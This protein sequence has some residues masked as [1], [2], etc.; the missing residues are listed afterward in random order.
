M[1]TFIPK[2]DPTKI[3]NPGE[4][5][6]AETL[7][8]HL[9]DDIRVIHSLNW[10]RKGRSGVLVEGECD[11]V[12]LVPNKGL[13]FVEVKGGILGFDTDLGEWWRLSPHNNRRAL[14]KDPFKQVQSNMHSILDHIKE[15][16]GVPTLNFTYGFATIFPDG[17]FQGKLPPGITR[18]QILDA[19]DLENPEKRLHSILDLFQRRN[20]TAL[21]RNE[22]H[23]IESALFTKFDIV[24]VT[25]RNLEEQ[26]RRLHRLTEEQRTLLDILAEQSTAAI[27]GG[28]GTGKTLLAVAKAQQVAQSGM[29]TLLLCYNRPLRNWLND[30]VQIDFEQKLM[31][32]TYHELVHEFCIAAEL[33]FNPNMTGDQQEFWNNHAPDLLMQACDK[34]PENKKFDAV[35]VD[36]GQDFQELWW[37]S[38]DSVFKEPNNKECFYVYFDP[39][40]NLFLREAVSLPS[41]LGNPFVLQRNCRNSPEIADYC[42]R[43]IDDNLDDA[44]H[45]LE[46]YQVESRRL[47]F[48]KIAELVHKLTKPRTGELKPSQIAVLV[49]P[50]PKND[51]PTKFKSIST[52]G[53]LDSW[54]SGKGVL[55]ETYPRFKG[56][57]ADVVIILTAPL[58]GADDRLRRFNYVACSRAKHILHIVEVIGN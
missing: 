45:S 32:K 36:E 43:I 22:I 52:T 9:S 53:D 47:G 37:H 1:V 16:L 28:A 21:S 49:P 15:H 44:T 26:E 23:R 14:N 30:T 5:K 12:I 57:E 10:V 33:D 25:W 39:N 40:Q 46:V 41:E 24:P 11:F 13:L 54:R 4:R 27:K 56:L 8:K 35:V 18:K 19:H 3:E 55:I 29:R 48:Q 58:D 7:S 6:V 51:W 2:L 42:N 31:I 17:I 20:S 34:L 38:L 50:F